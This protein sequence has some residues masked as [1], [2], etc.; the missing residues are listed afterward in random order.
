MLVLARFVVAWLERCHEHA[1]RASPL[2]ELHQA[3]TSCLS[4]S[5]PVSTPDCAPPV[6]RQVSSPAGSKIGDEDS[7]DGPP[8]SVGSADNIPG[9]TPVSSSK[10]VRAGSAAAPKR[11]TQG[12]LQLQKVHAGSAAAPKRYAQ[13]Q[14]QLQKVRAG[15]SGEVVCDTS[16]MVKC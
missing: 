4:H 1:V 6:C 15:F 7:L 13:G 8:A 11:Y 12:Q 10:K 2:I 16:K 3:S 5:P 14:L 9:V